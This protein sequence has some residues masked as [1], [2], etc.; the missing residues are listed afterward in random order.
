MHIQ[1]RTS[2]ANNLTNQNWP[3][4]RAPMQDNYGGG[5]IHPTSPSTATNFK[6][7][8]PHLP[9]HT[10]V[11]NSTYREHSSRPPFKC[12][13]QSSPPWAASSPSSPPYAASPITTSM[14]PTPFPAS[15]IPPPPP[16]RSSPS[17]YIASGSSTPYCNAYCSAF[18]C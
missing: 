7:G 12:P 6:Y 1:R 9:W 14:P 5:K 4:T 18:G 16:S 3:T 2:K 8:C 15:S 13:T 10:P 11:R 17:T